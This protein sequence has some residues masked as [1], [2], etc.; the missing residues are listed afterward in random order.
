MNLPQY[1]ISKKFL[2]NDNMPDTWVNDCNIP[3]PALDTEK[4]PSV[5]PFSGADTLTKYKVNS[6]EMPA[7]WIYHSKSVSYTINSEGY[8]SPEFHTV[9]WSNSVVLFGCSCVYGDGLDDSDTI[10]A[11][12]EKLIN[13]PVIN[14]GVSGSSIDFAYYNQVILSGM[15]PKPK[16]IINLWTS[17][18]RVSFFTK[19]KPKLL[20]PW[21]KSRL[22]VK[23]YYAGNFNDA[24]PAAHA[25]FL[26]QSAR[27]LWKDTLHKEYTFMLDPNDMHAD[28]WSIIK[29]FRKPDA[30][31]DNQH[32]GIKSAKLA[33][34]QIAKDLK[35]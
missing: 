27:I 6:A 2:P 34:E 26:R 33:A 18:T 20:G 15:V 14:M 8:R 25:Y 28:E 12:L 11:Q 31:R 1:I 35:L 7:D 3:T 22:Y 9:D 5:Q 19:L 29:R 4:K 13:V 32:P 10:S 17:A 23:L 21:L 30:A 24:N 16:A